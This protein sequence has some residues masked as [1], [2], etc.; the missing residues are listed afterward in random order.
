MLS[1]TQF[2]IWCKEQGMT[3][4]E[5]ADK[6]DVNISTI[7]KYWQGVSKPTRAVEQKMVEVFGIN[8]KEM[9]GFI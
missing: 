2:K 6:L 1:H 4:A 3:A 9:F 8:T 7:Y 5:V